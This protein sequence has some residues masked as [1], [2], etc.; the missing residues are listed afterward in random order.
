VQFPVLT[1]LMSSFGPQ[2]L[3]SIIYPRSNK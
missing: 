2:D 1:H 3:H